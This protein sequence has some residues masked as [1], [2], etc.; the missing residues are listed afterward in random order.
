MGY[1]RSLQALEA[2]ELNEAVVEALVKLFYY[3]Y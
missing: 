3:H 1:S 2:G